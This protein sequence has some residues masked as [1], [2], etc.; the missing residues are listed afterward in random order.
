MDDTNDALWFAFAALAKT[1][2][3]DGG[4]RITAHLAR[5]LLE[6]HRRLKM[7]APPIMQK[8]VHKVTEALHGPAREPFRRTP[9]TIF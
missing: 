1:H 9:V 2:P 7:P 3:H 4:V 8:I 5:W 6:E